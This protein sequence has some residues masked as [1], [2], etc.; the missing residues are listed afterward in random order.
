MNGIFRS[1]GFDLKHTPYRVHPPEEKELEIS[2]KRD[3]EIKEDQCKAALHQ[4]ESNELNEEIESYDDAYDS[5]LL[6]KQMQ[7]IWDQMG[8]DS[9]VHRVRGNTPDISNRKYP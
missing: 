8:Y 3:E 7:S 2:S 4:N 1:P 6:D 9:L 5:D